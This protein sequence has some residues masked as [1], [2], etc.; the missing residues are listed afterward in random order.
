MKINISPLW[1]KLGIEDEVS[2]VQ[3]LYDVY[4]GE[5]SNIGEIVYINGFKAEQYIGRSSNVCSFRNKDTIKNFIDY[6]VVTRVDNDGSTFPY[7]D[8][9]L[10]TD[11]YKVL[12]DWDN[13]NRYAGILQDSEADE[14]YGLAKQKQLI[15]ST[16][17]RID[18]A[19]KTKKFAVTERILG[20]YTDHVATAQA[21][22]S[23]DSTDHHI[24]FVE[25]LRNLEKDGFLKIHKIEFNF[26]ALPIP[27]EEESNRLEEGV[28]VDEDAYFYPAEH[29]KV[30]LELYN[31]QSTEAILIRQAD[32]QAIPS[33][34]PPNPFS[35][36]G[37]AD[38]V[39]ER[40]FEDKIQL[41]NKLLEI[42][43]PDD[44]EVE[45]WTPAELVKSDPI[46]AGFD[47]KETIEV[48]KKAQVITKFTDLAPKSAPKTH[49][50]Y[51]A[52]I[53]YD[54]LHKHAEDLHDEIESW[55][56]EAYGLEQQKKSLLKI[57]RGIFKEY[58]NE[59][60]FTLSEEILGVYNP[61]NPSGDP[62]GISLLSPDT[63]RPDIRYSFMRAMRELERA[64]HFVIKDVEINF[65]AKPKHTPSSVKRAIFA[66]EAVH[67]P[68][69][70]PPAHCEVTIEL[71][72][73]ASSKNFQEK[74]KKFAESIKPKSIQPVKTESP[75]QEER[76]EP[77]PHQDIKQAPEMSDNKR[78]EFPLELVLTGKVLKI[79]GY[80]VDEPIDLINMQSGGSALLFDPI[81]KLCRSQPTRWSTISKKKIEATVGFDKLS[82]FQEVIK[83]LTIFSKYTSGIGLKGVLRRLFIGKINDQMGITIRIAVPTKDWVSLPSKK[84]EKVVNSLLEISRS[85]SS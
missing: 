83:D 25:T 11:I 34:A 51:E 32:E 41:M 9:T 70:Y 36:K 49:H 58:P 50:L 30:T 27:T 55:K 69:F 31:S 4:F 2:L 18:K 72:Q 84:K 39:M 14:S 77:P 16:L 17:L 6:Q 10:E 24:K 71:P 8:K 53:D 73:T 7:F 43:S 26:D 21:I 85:R 52:I 5:E 59:K 79:Q 78:L 28:F 38:S 75:K 67:E 45:L 68:E 62:A 48:L 3:Q 47:H 61:S 22:R 40:F 42:V 44:L 37:I 33:E 29:C 19:S 57:L 65:Y 60:E 80:A 15:K 76:Q 13:L 46:R 12:I 35:L 63:H 20:K 23:D 74:I 81:F 66:V 54:N 56:G 64:G 82:S 1:S